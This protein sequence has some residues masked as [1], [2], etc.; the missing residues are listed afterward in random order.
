MKIYLKSF[1]GSLIAYLFNYHISNIKISNIRSFFLKL[2]L[3][4]FKS[5]SFVGKGVFILNGRK[6]IIKDKTFIS[7]GC[8]LDG[9]KFKIEIGKNVFIGKNS[10][11]I[12]LGH[13]LQS[14]D[15]KNKGGHVVIKDNVRI[16]ENVIILAGV[17]IGNN[18]EIIS[19]SVVTKNVLP[20]SIFGGKPALLISIKR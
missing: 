5:N 17:T 19:G 2:W 10:S 12:T 1:M 20:D 18:S 4:E 3:L 8:F 6:L 9:R 7:E 14:E 16:G 15:F 11:I 13:D